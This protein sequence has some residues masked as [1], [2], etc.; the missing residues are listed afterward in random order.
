MKPTPQFIRAVNEGVSTMARLLVEHD[1]LEID[2]AAIVLI[3]AGYP[4]ALFEPNIDRAVNEGRA[5]RASY[6]RPREVV[7]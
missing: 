3:Q 7:S 4:P 5:F 6:T 1:A 2:R